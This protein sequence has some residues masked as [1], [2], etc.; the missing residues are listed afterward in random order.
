MSTIT[1]HEAMTDQP[2]DADVATACERLCI[3]QQRAVVA[4]VNSLRDAAAG[5][6]G[7]SDCDDDG[8]EPTTT[9]AAAAPA[10]AIDANR[11]SCLSGAVMAWTRCCEEANIARV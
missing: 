2:A 8:I 7:G 4:C 6:R 10:S 1:I 11:E 5:P 3:E 9:N